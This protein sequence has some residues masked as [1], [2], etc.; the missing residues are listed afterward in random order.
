MSEAEV[1]CA[2]ESGL[3]AVMELLHLFLEAPRWEE[4][5]M[6]RAK[7]MWLSHYR[8]LGK[9]LERATADRIMTSMLGPDRCTHSTA[10]RSRM[11]PLVIWLLCGCQPPLGRCGCDCSTTLHTS[12]CLACEGPHKWGACK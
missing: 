11:S 4:S 7:Q 5:A 10:C 1:A 12:A 2:G 3:Q 9:G 6:A 8:A